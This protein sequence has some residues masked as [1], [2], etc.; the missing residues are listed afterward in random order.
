MTPTRRIPA[1]V[2]TVL[3][4]LLA[5]AQSDGGRSARTLEAEGSALS[6]EGHWQAAA[7]R[8][9]EAIA[10]DPTYA[11]ARYQFAASVF[12]SIRSDGCRPAASTA[13][14][15]DHLVRSVQLDRRLLKR[16]AQDPEFEEFR[17]TAGYFTLIG[18]DVHSVKGLRVLLPK[19]RVHAPSTQDSGPLFRL[20]FHADGTLDVFDHVLSTESWTW[21]K[22]SGRWR[23][24]PSV[25]GHGALVEL[26]VPGK[27]DAPA[28]HASYGVSAGRDGL[29]VVGEGGELFAVD[30]WGHCC[31]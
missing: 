22:R 20:E 8:L 1:M 24:R 6:K 29:V 21:T 17:H 31:C 9:R 5:S 12:L 27:N 25:S 18:D 10:V 14:A 3:S 11:L 23:A 19:L 15:F 7:E 13:E 30:T 4:A 28:L 26:D 16:L 2:A